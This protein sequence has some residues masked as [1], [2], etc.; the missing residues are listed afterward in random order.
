M[1]LKD[2]QD[3][4]WV[5]RGTTLLAIGGSRVRGKAPQGQETRNVRKA[6][7]RRTLFLT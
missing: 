1:A 7:G 6:G 5:S 4:V 3:V 2:T